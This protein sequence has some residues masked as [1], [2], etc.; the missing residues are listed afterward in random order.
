ML[1][2]SGTEYEQIESVY[3]HLKCIEHI[4]KDYKHVKPERKRNDK[5]RINSIKG[6]G[7]VIGPRKGH[8]TQILKFNLKMGS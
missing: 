1:K 2:A 8:T 3:K 4:I 5:S 6:K 7:E